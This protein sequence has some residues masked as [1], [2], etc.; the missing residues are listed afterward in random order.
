M[1]KGDANHNINDKKIEYKLFKEAKMNLRVSSLLYALL[2]WKFK[3]LNI[4]LYKLHFLYIFHWDFFELV[5][6][7]VVFV[8]AAVFVVVFVVVV[9]VVVAIVVVVIVVVVVYGDIM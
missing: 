1:K 6:V 2:N 8:V 7:V 3:K 5:F 9:F 4:L